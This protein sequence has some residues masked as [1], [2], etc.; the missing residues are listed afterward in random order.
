MLG[1]GWEV[2]SAP[3]R[4]RLRS[5]D[6]ALCCPGGIGPRLLDVAE[7]SGPGIDVEYAVR[8]LLSESGQFGEDCAGA[9]GTLAA[10]HDLEASGAQR[11]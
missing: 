5:N 10:A 8:D 2:L 3:A 11:G 4:L 6:Y 9:D 1:S 7:R